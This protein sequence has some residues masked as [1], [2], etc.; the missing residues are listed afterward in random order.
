MMTLRPARLEAFWAGGHTSPGS[1]N[2][3]KPLSIYPDFATARGRYKLSPPQQAGETFPFDYLAYHSL[4]RV[5]GGW[6]WKFVPAVLRSDNAGPVW[7][8]IASHLL[9]DPGRQAIIQGG[10]SW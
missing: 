5:E 6:S 4:R 9:A 3:D 1:G 10:V 2:P 8:T 7:L